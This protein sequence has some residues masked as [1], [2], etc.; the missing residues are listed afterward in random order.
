VVPFLGF[1]PARVFLRVYQGAL[2]HPGISAGV[3]PL[4]YSRHEAD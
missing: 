3:T 4:V 2:G 1:V